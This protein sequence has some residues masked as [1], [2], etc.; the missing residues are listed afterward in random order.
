MYI[1]IVSVEQLK[2]LTQIKLATFFFP[3]LFD[4]KR[5]KRI[6]LGPKEGR[7]DS[8]PCFYPIKAS[9]RSTIIEG[10]SSHI[11][12]VV[13]WSS[14]LG[15]STPDSGSSSAMRFYWIIILSYGNIPLY[16]VFYFLF[17]LE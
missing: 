8:G 7:G 1:R 2:Y 4:F 9:V 14:Y 15:G 5:W 6:R 10:M 13:R 11:L 12:F 17:L 16:P 3:T